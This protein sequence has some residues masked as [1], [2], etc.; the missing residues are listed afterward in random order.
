MKMNILYIVLKNGTR[1]IS[2]VDKLD[3]SEVGDPDCKLI[4]PFDISVTMMAESHGSCGP[5]FIPWESEYTNDSDFIIRSDDILLM[6]KPKPE[7]VKKYLKILSDMINNDTIV[8]DSPKVS[9]D[10][11]HPNK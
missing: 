11:G 7:L 5:V 3:P 1:L 9:N 2:Q 4:N 6:Q 8:V 10:T